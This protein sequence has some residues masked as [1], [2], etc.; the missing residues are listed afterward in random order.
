MTGRTLR[1]G[2]F[3][4]S[5]SLFPVCEQN[6]DP[7]A[8]VVSWTSAWRNTSFIRT[9]LRRHDRFLGFGRVQA[10]V[11]ND[12]REDGSFFRGDFFLLSAIPAAPSR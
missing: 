10:E 5:T 7:A 3:R 9:R 8:P 2:Y 1:N 4:L 11:I 12:R 6:S